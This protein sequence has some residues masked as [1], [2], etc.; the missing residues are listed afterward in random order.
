MEA[1]L[2]MGV[3]SALGIPR[4]RRYPSL[5]WDF[6]CHL[7]PGVDDGVRSLEEARQAIDGLRHLGY[8]GGVVTP[9]IY[10][11]VYDNSSANLRAAFEQFRIRVDRDYGLRLAAEYHATDEFVDLVS[12]GDL[13]FL[14]LTD[15]RLVLVEFPYMMPAPRGMDAI[16]ALVRA[17]YQPVLAHVER[18]RYIQDDP[19]M[20]LTRISRF[21]TWVQCNI[22]S[23]GGMYGKGPRTFARHLLA[24]GV[25]VIWGTDLHRPRQIDRYIVAGLQSLGGLDRLNTLLDELGCSSVP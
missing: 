17:G 25:P 18:Y 2:A 6:H 12:D 21:D 15:R 14:P 19:D 22:G 10:A 11:G 9:H 23:L 24:Q 13:L 3:F 5:G 8:C 7:I 1:V 20:W 4:A 16:G